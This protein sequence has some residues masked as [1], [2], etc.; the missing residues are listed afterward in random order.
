VIVVDD[1]GISSCV[2]LFVGEL[3]S[4]TRSRPWSRSTTGSPP[5]GS[6]IL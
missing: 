2:W 5:I 3:F 6:G 4:R 1:E